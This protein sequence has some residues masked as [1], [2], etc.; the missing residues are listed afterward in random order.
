MGAAGIV[1]PLSAVASIPLG[2]ATKQLVALAHWALES[3]AALAGTVCANHAAPSKVEKTWA[4][5]APDSVAEHCIDET[6]MIELMLPATEAGT[7]S[8]VQD[9]PELVVAATVGDPDGF[10]PPA[11][12]TEVVGHDI[13]V[14]EAASAGSVPATDDQVPPLLVVSNTC[15]TP[16]TT[17]VA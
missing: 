6:Q 4:V 5:I 11:R 9:A 1:S 14:S 16:P 3:T 12:Q 7:Y 2:P 17:P 10:S 13:E 8:G 15:V